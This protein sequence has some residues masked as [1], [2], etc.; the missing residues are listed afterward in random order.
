MVYIVFETLLNNTTLVQCPTI[1]CAKL[2]DHL[3]VHQT[4]ERVLCSLPSL[5]RRAS[6]YLPPASPPLPP[7]ATPVN[8]GIQHIVPQTPT[9]AAVGRPPHYEHQ[10][11]L[12]G[13][14]AE[15]GRGLPAPHHSFSNR[16]SSGF[17]S[18]NPIDERWRSESGWIWRQRRWSGRKWRYHCRRSWQTHVVYGCRFM[19]R[20][21]HKTNSF[22][23]A[24]PNWLQQ[25]AGVSTYV[26]AYSMIVIFHSCKNVCSFNLHCY[27]SVFSTQA[28]R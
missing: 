8:Q 14:A 3:K 12:G 4:T 17:C 27:L 11:H 24:D 5:H 6:S 18:F 10:P 1:V 26:L 22:A 28:S 21:M 23:L 9:P 15:A 2:E 25:T 20:D 7:P 19:V 13:G 16:C